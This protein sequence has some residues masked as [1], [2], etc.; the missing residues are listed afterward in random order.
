MFKFTQEELE[1]AKKYTYVSQN[2][3][4]EIFQNNNM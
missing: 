4:K 3:A 1:L 2:E